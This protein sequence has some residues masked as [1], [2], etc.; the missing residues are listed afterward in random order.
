ML[1]MIRIETAKMIAE[2]LTSGGNR[3]QNENLPVACRRYRAR[4]DWLFS[5]Y[6]K[7]G[8]GNACGKWNKNCKTFKREGTDVRRV[9][10]CH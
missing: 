1:L 4:K 5:G 7:V 8:T 2:I 3:R 9:I 6:K 10:S